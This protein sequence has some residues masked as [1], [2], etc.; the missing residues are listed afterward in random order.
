MKRIVLLSDGTGNSSATL[1]KTNVWRMYQA[2]DLE[3]E[4]NVVRQI[5]CYNDGVGTSAFRPLAL[6]GGAFGYGLKRNVLHLYEFLCQNWED[7]DEIYIFGFSRGAFTGRVLAGLIANKGVLVN[8]DPKKVHSRTRHLYRE[9]RFARYQV[10]SLPPVVLLAHLIRRGLTWAWRTISGK[11][12]PDVVEPDIEFLGVW[13]TVAAYGSPLAELTRGIDRFVFPLSMP[14]RKL[15]DKILRARHALA[16]DDERDTFHPLLWDEIDKKEPWNRLQQVWFAGMHADVGGGYPDDALSFPPLEWMMKEASA[17][18]GLKYLDHAYERF[19]PPPSQSAVL[20]DSRQGLSGYYRYQPRRLSAYLCPDDPETAVM[21][22][23]SRKAKAHVKRIT[24]HHSVTDRISR[25]TDRYAPIVMPEFFDVLD[26]NG[27]VVSNVETPE[28]RT[29]RMTGQK[30]VWDLVWHKRVNYFLMVG[31]SIVFAALPFWAP[32]P[33]SA[34]C[35]WLVCS[36]SPII[37]MVGAFV[38]AFLQTWIDA[39]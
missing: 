20:H 32:P 38:P 30:R 10:V 1:F 29:A 28:A 24:L 25:S 8:C 15:N 31:V 11:P 22:D 7:G 37:R 39:I 19:A 21:R 18:D 13:D 12:R 6:L 5:A 34:A 36:V 26:H 2:L 4:H 35:E 16:L 9:F 3:T 23:S 33:A 17:G 14:D 27:D